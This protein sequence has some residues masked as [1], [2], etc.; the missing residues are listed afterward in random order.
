MGKDGD[1]CHQRSGPDGEEMRLGGLLLAGSRAQ[2]LTSAAALQEYP[3]SA[4]RLAPRTRVLD[5]TGNS[6]TSLPPF[7]S[8]LT[9]LQRLVL[10]RNSIQA[11]PADL[12]PLA[13][14]RVSGAG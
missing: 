5:A 13:H 1:D 2:P 14:L 4:E 7:L 8:A 9:S 6:L 3:P 12:S 11:L 10:T